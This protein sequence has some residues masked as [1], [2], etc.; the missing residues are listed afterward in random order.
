MQCVTNISEYV[1]HTPMVKCVLL[2]DLY[3]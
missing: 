3:I 1:R 2:H